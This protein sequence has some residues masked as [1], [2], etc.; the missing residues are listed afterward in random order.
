MYRVGMCNKWVAWMKACVFGGSMSILVN[1]SPTEEI[2]IHRGLKQGDPLA[3]FLF[4]L[5]VEG[6]SGLMRNAVE[7]NLFEG[8][9]FGDNV[10]ML[11]YADDTICIGKPSVQN[12]W[13]LKAVL[14]GFEMVSGLKI[15]FS[16]S[17][18]IGVNVN[19]DFMEMA[20]DFLNCSRGSLPFKYLGLPVGANMKSMTT[21]EPLVDCLGRRLNT[22]GHRYLSFGGRIVLLNSILNSMPIFYLSFLK[23]PV[24]VWKRIVRLQREFL[25]G[26][27]G[28][29]KK[30]N[31]VK[32]E[33]VCQHKSNGGLGV[34]AWR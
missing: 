18:L 7:G 24:Q 3:P 20:C 25:W 23:M 15:N 31:W 29:G 22:W 30:I 28:G 26:G 32:W 5:V 9:C 14:R 11:Q 13:T 4:L 2:S 34:V 12:L 16:K 1:G 19:E 33:S 6:F 10:V 17:A 27:V 21:W 8:F